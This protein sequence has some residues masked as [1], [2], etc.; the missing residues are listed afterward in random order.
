M[1]RQSDGIWPISSA[2]Q[3]KIKKNG[4]EQDK[5]SKSALHLIRTATI[6]SA[7]Y[8]FFVCVKKIKIPP[9]ECWLPYNSITNGSNKNNNSNNTAEPGEKNVITVAAQFECV[10]V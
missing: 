4:H 7:Q 2:V 5:Y 9:C 10:N 1:Q 8:V 6:D 3:R